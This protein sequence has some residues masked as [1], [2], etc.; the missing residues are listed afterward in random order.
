MGKGMLRG[1]QGPGEGSGKVGSVDRKEG[2]VR[3]GR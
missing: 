3:R 1:W 2:W